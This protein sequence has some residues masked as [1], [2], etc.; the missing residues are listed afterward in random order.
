MIF[1]KKKKKNLS[2]ERF[3]KLIFIKLFRVNDTPQKVAFGLGLGVFSGVMPGTGPL[4][5]LFLASLLRVNKSSALLGGIL[6][7]T[8]SIIPILGISIKV[9]AAVTGLCW[10]DVNR[11][12]QAF[13]AHFHLSD[14]FKLSILK[15]IMPVIIGY[16]LVA[17]ISGVLAYIIILPILNWLRYRKL[18]K[19]ARS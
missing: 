13:L 5:A 15:V 12:W 10:Q 14:L 4:A 19:T 1:P 16:F 9:G 6:T 11:S 8:W 18:K 3:L 2:I 7:N 17:L